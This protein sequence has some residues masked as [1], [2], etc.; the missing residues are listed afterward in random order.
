MGFQPRFNC[1]CFRDGGCTHQA[2][3]RKLFGLPDCI[4]INRPPVRD[5]RIGPATCAVRVPHAK[6]L[7]PPR[8]P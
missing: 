1:V 8:Q 7:L 2:A 4:E 5:H 6:P 3:P